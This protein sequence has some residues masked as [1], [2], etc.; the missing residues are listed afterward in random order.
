MIALAC[1]IGAVGAAVGVFSA[2]RLGTN[3]A[4]AVAAALGLLFALAFLFAPHRGQVAILLRRREQRRT[5]EETMLAVHL[6]QHEGTPAEADEARADGLH[7]HLHW[8][9]VR[10]AAVVERATENGLVVRAGEL[11]KLTEVGRERARGVFG[12]LRP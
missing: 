8:D 7:E 9:A 11:L 12:E 10:V 1:G 2:E 4:G 3:T 6:Y 5:F